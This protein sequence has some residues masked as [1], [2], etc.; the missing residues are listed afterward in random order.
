[1]P[2]KTGKVHESIAMVIANIG[3]IGKDNTNDHFKYEYRSYEQ[4]IAGLQPLFDK[5]GLYATSTISDVHITTGDKGSNPLTTATVTY[6]VYSS[7]DGSFVET[8]VIAQ[9]K[10]NADK[11]AYKLM[12]GAIKYAFGQLF[13]I[14]FSGDDA[15]RTSHDA[16]KPPRAQNTRSNAPQGQKPPQAANG[17]AQLYTLKDKPNWSVEV[18]WPKGGEKMYGVVEQLSQGQIDK[19]RKAALRNIEYWDGRGDDK[20]TGYA[21]KDLERIEKQMKAMG[22]DPLSSR[23]HPVGEYD[24]YATS[25]PTDQSEPPF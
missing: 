4:I 1:M 3:V 16:S 10:D 2:E 8:S 17:E 13:M 23:P 5:H 25:F 20:K 12:S 11:G 24:D 18:E 14:P 9:G 15:E 19:A 6:R 7:E 21:R 22:V